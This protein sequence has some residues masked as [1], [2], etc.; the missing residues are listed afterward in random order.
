MTP[1]TV[2]H[3]ALLSVGFP[4][5]EYYSG[6]PVPSPGDPFDREGLNSC[7]LHWQAD[8]L[9]L[10]YQGSLYYVHSTFLTYDWKIY[11]KKL[12]WTLSV[13]GVCSGSPGSVRILQTSSGTFL[14]LPECLEGEPTNG[15]RCLGISVCSYMRPSQQCVLRSSTRYLLAI[16]DDPSSCL[17]LTK[18]KKRISPQICAFGW[19]I[20]DNLWG[21][22]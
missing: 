8:S 22:K 14:F 3:Q 11:N 21:G 10:S 12:S 19:T 18:K 4:R 7:L 5:Q 17:H 13:W 2:A 16:F 15:F 1:W 20:A 9:L 6:L